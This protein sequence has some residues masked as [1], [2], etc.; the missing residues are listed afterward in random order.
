MFEFVESRIVAGIADNVL[1]NIPFSSTCGQVKVEEP[2][3]TH[4]V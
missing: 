3:P 4:L 2:V 1:N